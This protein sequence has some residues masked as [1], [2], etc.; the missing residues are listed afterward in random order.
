MPKKLNAL[1]KKELDQRF[2]AIPSGIVVDYQGLPSEETFALR[3]ELRSKNIKMLVVK[4]SIAS[5]ALSGAGV[6]NAG[7]L[8]KG[9]VA[10]CFNDDPVAVA[11]ALV[12]WKKKNKKTKLAIKGGILD[13]R[14]ITSEDVQKLAA[15]PG[16]KQLLAQLAGTFAAPMQGLVQATAGIIRKLGY[17]LNAVKEQK[18]KQGGAAA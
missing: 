18:E 4:N 10:V 6:A 16:R 5:S 17:A 12:D 1:L 11:G 3:K 13:R 14:V 9:P 7:A 2:E 8:L 15:M